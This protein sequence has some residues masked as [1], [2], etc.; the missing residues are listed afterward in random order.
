M[1]RDLKSILSGFKLNPS[2]YNKLR[3]LEKKCSE[4]T[5]GT[6][7]YE[8]MS[9]LKHSITMMRKRS[10]ETQQRNIGIKLELSSEVFIFHQWRYD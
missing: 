9:S 1:N 3:L 8:K 2:S 10:V 4:N 7:K 6:L 5:Y